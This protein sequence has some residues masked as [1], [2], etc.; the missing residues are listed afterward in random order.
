VDKIR[1]GVDRAQREVVGGL[2][3]LLDKIDGDGGKRGRDQERK[4]DRR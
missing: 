1:E 3:G 2:R 4:P